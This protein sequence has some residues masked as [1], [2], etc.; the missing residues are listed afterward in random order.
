[1]I[2]CLLFSQSALGAAFL[3][4]QIPVYLGDLVQ[5]LSEST[6]HEVSLSDYMQQI[7]EPAIKLLSA[8][9]MQ[10]KGHLIF[11]NPRQIH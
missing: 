6:S 2:I 1:M 8:Y 3:N 5:V 7:K 9:G 11:F 4:I 10:V